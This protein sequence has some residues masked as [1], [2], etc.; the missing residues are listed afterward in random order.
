MPEHF[1]R[2]HGGILIH[3]GR[4]GTLLRASGGMHRFAIARSLDLPEIPAQPGVVHPQA[5]YMNIL[6]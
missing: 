4:E 6:A 3:P 5:L 1:R 2:A